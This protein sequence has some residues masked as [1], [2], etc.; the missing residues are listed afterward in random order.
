MREQELELK[1]TSRVSKE[2][3]INVN[4]MYR[5]YQKFLFERLMRIFIWDS[6]PFPQRELEYRLLKAGGA[7]VVRDEKVGTMVT[8][9]SLSGVTQYLDV[10][11]YV[12]YAAPTAKG[13]TLTIGEDALVVYNTDTRLE[14]QSHVD[15]YASLLAHWY[16]S[17]KLSLV[18]YRSQE[19]LVANNDN[20]RA[21]IQKWYDGMYNG[22]PLA[23]LDDTLMELGNG[24]LNLSSKS[25]GTPLN[26]LIYAGNDIMRS[27]YRDIGIRYVKEKKAN[28]V[29]DEVSSDDQMLLY[30]INDMSYNRQKFVEEYNNLFVP[31]FG[32][33]PIS[34]RLNPLFKIIGGESD[35]SKNVSYRDDKSDTK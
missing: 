26:D 13:G 22:K 4:Y 27:F 3:S 31:K 17:V 7:A 10:F 11:R 32:E 28:M 18:N 2:K 33:K 25:S 34:C 24:I 19:I 30:N 20:T 15:S 9:A 16:M 6:L 5:Y 23:I 35:D 1:S 29:A 8:W 12:T 14:M 21:N